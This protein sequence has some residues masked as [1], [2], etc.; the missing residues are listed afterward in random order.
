MKKLSIIALVIITLCATVLPAVSVSASTQLEAQAIPLRVLGISAPSDVFVVQPVPIK[1]YDQM[2]NRPVSWAGVWALEIDG[3]LDGQDPSLLADMARDSGDFLGWTKENGYIIPYPRFTDAGLY[4]LVAMKEGW[5]PAFTTMEVKPHIPMRMK[6]P[7]EVFVGQPIPIYVSDRND[8]SPIN[9]ACVWAIDLS[10]ASNIPEDADACFEL[11]ERHG[12]YLGSTDKSGYVIPYP[13]LTDPGRYILL[14][15]KPWHTPAYAKLTVKPLVPMGI[16]APAE[17]FVGQPIPIYV[18]DRNDGSPINKARVWAI[19]LSIASDIPED[20]DACTE[21][22]ERHGTYLGSTNE[23]GYVIPYPRLT[24]PGRYVLLALKP[25]HIPACT[26]LLVKPLGDMGIKAPDIVS[27]GRPVPIKV[28]DQHD[29]DPI[30]RAGVWAV[31][32]ALIS[33]VTSDNVAIAETAQNNGSYLGWTNRDGYVD[34]Y[35]RFR[36]PG[37]YALVALKHGYNPAV[38][39]IKVVQLQP[40]VAEKLTTIR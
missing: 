30:Y 38:K 33:E 27:V 10:I 24:D 20:E 25:W 21:L 5:N 26:R 2:T 3:K 13:H 28:Y 34:P 7:E 37:K 35:P 8:G 39:M 6:A 31:E 22:A 40:A 9:E 1:V 32:L 29:G 17:V 15:L 11:A 12:I 36:D 23:S 19:D 4:L 14:A 18:F 16:R